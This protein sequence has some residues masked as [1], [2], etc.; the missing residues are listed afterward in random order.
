MSQPQRINRMLLLTDGETFGDDQRCRELASQAAEMNMPI[1]ALGLGDEWN[2]NLLDSIAQVS[3][4]FSDF[5]PEKEPQSIL[6]AFEH[7]V[8]QAQGAVIQNA[9][10]TLR[11]AS[12]VSP[13]QVWQVVPLISRLDHNVLSDRDVQVSLGA[14]T[15]NEGG[16]ILVE[17]MLPRRQA[18][19]YRIA[20]AELAYDV[21]A[22]QSSDQKIRGDVIVEYTDD[23][24]L[25]T[26]FNPFVMNVVE[27]VTAHKLQ[28]RALSEA[29]A[30]NIAAATRRLRAAATRLL[31]L[32]EEELAQSALSEA[33]NLEQQ[34]QMSAAGTRKLRYE[35]RKLT[36]KT[37]V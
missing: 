12:G 17:L 6:R 15:N 24:R 33:Q 5:I 37:S 36:R 11:L 4:G 31:D 13:R 27:K 23:D 10:M 8:Q 18:G 22:S 20:Q 29:D 1:V 28:T 25:P 34:G 35:T 3:G 7:T 32:G 26:Q 19:K 14:I 30:G 2:M 21:A 9:H 16:S